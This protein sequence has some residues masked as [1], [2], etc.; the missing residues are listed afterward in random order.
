MNNS[1]PV[2]GLTDT[3]NAVFQRDA[4][5]TRAMLGKFMQ[6]ADDYTPAPAMNVEHDLTVGQP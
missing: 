5:D 4:I 1:R 6:F 3:T 2:T